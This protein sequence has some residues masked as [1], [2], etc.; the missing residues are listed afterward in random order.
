MFLQVGLD[1]RRSNTGTNL[2]R[3]YKYYDSLTQE[4]DLA[5]NK[6][7]S[8][9]VSQCNDYDFLCK[10]FIPG[11]GLN[12]EILEE[13]PPELNK[14]YGK[15]LHIWQYPKQLAKYLVWLSKNAKDVNSYM[16]IGC[17]WGGTFILI[18]EWLLKIGAPLKNSIAVDPIE[19]TPFLKRYMEISKHKV[20]YIKELSTSPVFI[21]QQQTFMPDMVFIDGDH[22]LGGVTNDHL[23]VR[24]YAKIIAH[25]DIFSLACP[26]TT[27]F[28]NFIKTVESNFEYDEFTDQY[29]SVHGHFLGIGVLKKTSIH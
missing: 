29:E 14:Y 12:N 19:P 20:I 11:L 22:S 16:E 21:K 5:I 1:I 17:R 13:Q 27:R 10:E 4:V 18:N 28:W 15:G 26:T 8:L 23:L 3:R 6:I 25:H 9:S 7:R 2:K 24:D